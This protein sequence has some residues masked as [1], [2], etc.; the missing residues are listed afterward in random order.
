METTPN[1]LQALAAAHN[2]HWVH[3]AGI[4]QDIEALRRICLYH[5]HWWNNTAWP[6]LVAAAGSEEAALA[7]LSLPKPD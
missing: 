1:P 5:S 2:P 6:A 3:N 4:T 7:L